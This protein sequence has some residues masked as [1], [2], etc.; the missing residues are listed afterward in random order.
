[1]QGLGTAPR[2]NGFGMS[3][4]KKWV[5][6]ETLPRTV[7]AALTPVSSKVYASGVHSVDN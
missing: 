5:T 1:M 6:S 4:W 7:G 3:E 2:I